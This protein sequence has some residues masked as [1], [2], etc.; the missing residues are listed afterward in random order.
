MGG[1]RY[2]VYASIYIVGINNVV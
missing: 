2:L 1:Y